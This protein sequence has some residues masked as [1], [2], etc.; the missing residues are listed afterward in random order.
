[1][2][3]VTIALENVMGGTVGD[4]SMA[5]SRDPFFNEGER[6]VLFVREATN[7]LEVLEG[8]AGKISVNETG[9]VRESGRSLGE[10]RAELLSYVKG[11]SS[12]ADSISDKPRPPL[13]EQRK[14]PGIQPNFVAE[15]HKWPGSSPVVQYFINN[16][17]FNDATAGTVA[18][19]NAA[20]NNGAN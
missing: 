2:S 15:G 9:L 16:P 7:G 8:K 1:N 11:L 19:Q 17:G 14:G 10:L 6:V 12:P 3:G 5:T 4:V 18:Q 13:A 20:I